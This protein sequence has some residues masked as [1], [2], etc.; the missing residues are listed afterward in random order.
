VAPKTPTAPD[1]KIDAIRITSSCVLTP[2]N[3]DNSVYGLGEKSPHQA[4]DHHH[5]FQLV[6]QVVS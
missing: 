5:P 6:L 2:R 1:V 3:D 4:G